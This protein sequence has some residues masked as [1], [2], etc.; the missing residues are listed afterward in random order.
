MDKIDP[1]ERGPL[2]GIPFSVKD[3]A[4]VAGYDCTAG[5]SI[6]LNN[7]AKQDSSLVAALKSLGAIPF[8]KTNVPQSLL[9]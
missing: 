6:N 5:L 1:S 2:H 7:P 3:N 9:R 8:C 4:S